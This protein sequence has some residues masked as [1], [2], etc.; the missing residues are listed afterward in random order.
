MKRL[1]NTTLLLVILFPAGVVAQDIPVFSLDT[2]LNRIAAHNLLLQSFAYKADSYREA[3]AGANAWMAPMIGAGTFMTPYPGQKVMD[4]DKGQL[5]LQLEQSIPNRAKQKA[6]EAWLI[7]RSQ[8]E[9]AGRDVTWNDFRATAKNLYS[10][11]QTAL[12]KI[13]VLRKNEALLLMM[14]K[15]EEVRLPYNQS[16]LGNIYKAEAA[17]EENRNRIIMEEGTI[18]E[19]MAMLNGM[20]N[21][22]ATLPFQVDTTFELVF[23]PVLVDTF[24]LASSRKDIYRMDENIRSMFSGINAMEL[25]RKPE[26]RIRFDHMSPLGGMM[27][28]AFSIMGM[29]SIPIAPWSSG[30]YKSE[31]RSMRSTIR[32]MEL[33]RGAMLQESMGRIYGMMEQIRRMQKKLLG[34]KENVLPALQRSMDV[35]LIGYQENRLALITVIDSWEALT[36]MQLQVLEEEFELSKMIISYEKELYR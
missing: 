6:K 34:M 8:A 17:V 20:M 30:M 26:F 25:E 33:E 35:N 31:I 24:D 7:S 5:M 1:I 36:M 27:P 29:V 19:A 18:S 13:D 32:S 3:A 16:L 21:R 15:I 28:H 11:W 10:S 14:K 2:V 12:K 4:N 22:Q 9:L 23:T